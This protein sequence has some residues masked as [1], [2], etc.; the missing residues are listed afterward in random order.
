GGV[1]GRDDGIQEVYRVKLPGN[2]VVGEGKP[3]NQNHAMIFTRGEHL[4][5]IDMNQEGYFE[6]ALKM[7]CLLEEFRGG[8]ARRPAVVVG[9]REHIFTGS[10]SSLANYMALQ[11]LSF[12][13]LGQRVL[14]NPLRVRM[15]YGHPDLFDKV[16]FMTAGGV[17]K[18]SK[19]INLSEDIFAGYNGTIRGGQV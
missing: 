2:P 13:T 17:S 18:A 3:E 11:E 15:H 1:G 12:V 5:A 6:E 19:G 4:Q 7:R 10:V 8:T 14:N 16:F 9:F